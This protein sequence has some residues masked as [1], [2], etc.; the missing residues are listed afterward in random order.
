MGADK[1]RE[2]KINTVL[3]CTKISTV[4][5]M[6]FCVLSVIFGYYICLYV[7]GI[8]FIGGS[9][10]IPAIPD[11]PAFV[12][13]MVAFYICIAFAFVILIGVWKLLGNLKSGEVFVRKNTKLLNV[14]TIGCV[15]IGVFCF[16]AGLLDY[17]T[18]LIGFVGFFM[19]LIVQCVKVLMDKAIDIKDEL[20]LTI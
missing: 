6:I 12:L 16:L 8:K 20:D 11:D 1:S 5:M 3:L 18:V 17:S 14:I 7:W 9:R 10:T 15:G 13:F 2:N 4:V 19:A